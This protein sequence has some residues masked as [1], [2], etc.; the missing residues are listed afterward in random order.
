MAQGKLN[1]LILPAS[2]NNLDELICNFPSASWYSTE[3]RGGQNGFFLSSHF[4]EVPRERAKDASRDTRVSSS[5]FIQFFVVPR[6]RTCLV[7]GAAGFY[8]FQFLLL[9]DHHLLLLWCCAW[10]LPYSGLHKYKQ[11]HRGLYKLN[12]VKLFKKN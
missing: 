4:F 5:R 10:A 1:K 8:L 7:C 3:N 6:R 11:V 12:T 9:Q 2:K